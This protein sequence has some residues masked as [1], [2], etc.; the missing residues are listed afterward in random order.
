MPGMNPNLPLKTALLTS[1]RV[2]IEKTSPVVRGVLHYL[3]YL[4]LAQDAILPAIVRFDHNHAHAPHAQKIP[5]LK[6]VHRR[7]VLPIPQ[8]TTSARVAAESLRGG[9]DPKRLVMRRHEE[10]AR[11]RVGQLVPLELPADV[12][13]VLAPEVGLG[14]AMSVGALNDHALGLHVKLRE[15]LLLGVVAVVIVVAGVDADFDLG[16]EPR[17]YLRGI[18]G[19]L[20]SPPAHRASQGG[21]GGSCVYRKLLFVH[22]DRELVYLCW[23]GSVQLLRPLTCGKVDDMNMMVMATNC[24]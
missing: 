18:V 20:R 12:G 8:Q 17:V 15:F 10:L 5:H 23:K 14:R 21:G 24:N 3:L 1:V 6:R 9:D 16:V 2:L 19:R 22:I 7:R 11:P 13:G 4:L